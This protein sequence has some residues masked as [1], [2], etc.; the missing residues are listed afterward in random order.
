MLIKTLSEEE[1]GVKDDGTYQEEE[2]EDM[3][4]AND[5]K[6]TSSDED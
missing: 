1:G 3:T 6:D 5:E 4:D 2:N